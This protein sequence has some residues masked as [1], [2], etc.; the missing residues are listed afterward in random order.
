MRAV[1]CKYRIVDVCLHVSFLR[2]QSRGDGEENGT[3]L[4]KAMVLCYRAIR[5]AMSLHVG[6]IKQFQTVTDKAALL[7][8][9]TR[10]H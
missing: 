5:E 9:R 2:Y 3:N 10:N 8:I 1:Y 6:I 7:V 4:C